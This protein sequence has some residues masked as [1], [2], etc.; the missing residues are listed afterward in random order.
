MKKYIKNILKTVIFFALLTSMLQMHQ[1]FAQTANSNINDILFECR[2][3]SF[4]DSNYN[5]AVA[6][7]FASYEKQTGTKIAPA[8]KAKVGLKIYT[9][10]GAG[11]C[12]PKGLV[13][14]VIA[15]LEKRGYKRENISLVDMS[16]RKMRDCGFLPRVSQIQ[17][18]SPDNYK[19]SPVVDIDSG[20]YFNSQWYYDNALMPK[21]LKGIT[22]SSDLYNPEFR[23]SYLPVPLFLTVDF[24]INLPVITDMDGLGVCAALG[25][26][27][28]WNMSNNERFLKQPAN[29]SMASAEV[30]AIPELRSSNLL[31][32]LSFE[33]GQYVGGAI[34]NARCSFSENIIL[35]SANP[36]AI[37]YLAWQAI[38]RHRRTF[39]FAPIDP[40]PPILNYCRELKIGDYDF[41]KIKR[42]DVPYSSKKR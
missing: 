42:I 36:V 16:R 12:T 41:R 3:P 28:I 17:K 34:F 4:N 10:S 5:R 1:L 6:L 29:A 8:Q 35:M 39:G 27:S 38:N 13:D 33:R 22:A 37:D 19:G 2:V 11:M 40:M 15:Q 30:C 23:K 14:A 7:L 20:K 21:A 32:I 25:N 26:A 31:T 24:W 9:N 18:G